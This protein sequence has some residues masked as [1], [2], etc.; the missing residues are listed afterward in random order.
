MKNRDT[1]A[2]GAEQRRREDNKK[3]LF[4]VIDMVGEG[5]EGVLVDDTDLPRYK[6]ALK[7]AAHIVNKYLP[8][9]H[10][11]KT[12]EV[13]VPQRPPHPFPQIHS[14]CACVCVCVCMCVCARV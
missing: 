6:R 3:Q 11:L 2:A 14:V 8:L 4:R 1:F 10:D 12:I 5:D 13:G 9:Q 7:Q